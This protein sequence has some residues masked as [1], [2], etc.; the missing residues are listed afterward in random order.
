MAAFAYLFI[1]GGMLTYDMVAYFVEYWGIKSEILHFVSYLAFL[2][3]VMCIPFWCLYAR[4][5][6]FT[7]DDYTRQTY[8]LYQPFISRRVAWLTGSPTGRRYLSS[9]RLVLFMGFPLANAIIRLVYDYVYRSC[10]SLSVHEEISHWA[11][12]VGYLM[13]GSFCYIVYIERVSFESEVEELSRLARENA[14]THDIDGMCNMLRQFHEHFQTLRRQISTWMALTMVVATWGLTAH[15]TWNYLIFTDIYLHREKYSNEALSNIYFLDVLVSA[16]KIMFCVLPYM[17]LGGLNLE[18]VWSALRI[19]IAKHRDRQNMDF[20]VFIYQH[21]IDMH[22]GSRQGM[23][24]ALIFTAIGL[25]LGL[26]LSD[27]QH[28]NFWDAPRD[29]NVTIWGRNVP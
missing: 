7:T 9:F 10:P 11:A 21:I 24:P 29:C 5:Q 28:V 6:Y 23:Q 3:Q 27:T 26:H 14:R 16:Q 19:N 15:L 13:Y 2:V 20:W 25:Y 8:S 18:H 4:V 12:V 22:Y 1:T 17:A